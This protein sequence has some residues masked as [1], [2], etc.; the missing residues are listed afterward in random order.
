MKGSIRFFLGFLI[1]VGSVG[2]DTQPIWQILLVAGIGLTMMY[3][4]AKALNESE[5]NE[6][7]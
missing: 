4:G 3:S 2:N 5:R 1:T 7:L 6:Y